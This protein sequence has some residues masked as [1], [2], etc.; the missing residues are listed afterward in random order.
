[1]AC[2]HVE[3]LPDC[4]GIRPSPHLLYMSQPV[5]VVEDLVLIMCC[6]ACLPLR[7]LR[8]NLVQLPA[9]VQVVEELVLICKRVH[10]SKLRTIP[11]LPNWVKELATLNEVGGCARIGASKQDLAQ[12]QGGRGTIIVHFKLSVA[13]WAFNTRAGRHQPL[14]RPPHRRPCTDAGQRARQAGAARAD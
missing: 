3:L 12:G 2:L 1:M 4:H 13:C 14:P 5:Q 6:Q 10:R 9:S 11:P 8:S 7:H